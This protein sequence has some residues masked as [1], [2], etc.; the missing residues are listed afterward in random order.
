MGIAERLADPADPLRVLL[1]AA[2]SWRVP[3][4]VFLRQRTVNST[5]WTDQDTSY[6]LALEDYEAGLCP[7]CNHPLAET[8]QA[9]PRRRLP[10]GEADPLPLLHGAGDGGGGGGEGRQHGRA[11]V[12][13]H[14]G[15]GCGRVEPEAGS[16]AATRVGVAQP[17]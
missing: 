6:A 8:S 12:P 9:G 3:P 15:P 11:H 17:G 5:D 14:L 13:A 1:Q 4:T 2:R 10:P 16:A 7:G